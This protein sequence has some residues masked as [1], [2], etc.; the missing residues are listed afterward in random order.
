[1]KY[2]RYILSVTLVLGLTPSILNAQSVLIDWDHTWNYLHPI[3]GALPRTSGTSPHPTGTTPWHAIQ[4]EFEASYAGPSFSASA[5]GFEGGQGTAPF[6]YGTIDYFGNPIPAPG[7]FSSFATALPI[8]PTGSRYTNYFRTT[9][10]VPDDGA[11]YNN[12][13]LRYILDD[14]GFIYLN[15]QLILQVNMAAGI[16]DAYSTLAA[17]TVATETELRKAEL[18]LA[19]GSLTGGNS[20]TGLAGN[21]TVSQQVLELPPG[22]HT[23]A[24]AVHSASNGSSDM[25]LALQLQAGDPKCTMEAT[26]SN[27]VES[28]GGTPGNPGDDT[29]SFVLNVSATG[30]FGTSWK[31][32]APTSAAHNAGGT[33]GED[34]EISGL[35]AGE[36]TDGSLSLAIEDADD[37]LCSTVVTIAAPLVIASD[38][39]G[40]SDIPVYT[41]PDTDSSGWIINGLERSMTMNN[42]GGSV[43]RITS[44]V[45]RL[46][47]SREILFSGVLKIDDTSSGT[48]AADSFNAYLIL[49]GNPDNTIS[50]ITPYDTGIADGIL[51]G[52][53]LAPSPG[54]YTLD[55]AATI[56]SSARS[57]QIVIEAINNSDSEIFT[58]SDLTFFFPAGSEPKAPLG[59]ERVG[60]QLVFT[61]ASGSGLL[62]NLRSESTNI[63]SD[64]LTWPIF[65]DQGALTATPPQ[66]TLTVPMP[67]EQSRLFVIESY[68][69]PPE[70][71]YGSDFENGAEEWETGSEGADGTVWELG[72]P[73][74]GPSEAFSPDNCFAT[75]LDS[76][77]ALNANVYLRSPPIVLSGAGGATL[78]FMHYYD[79]E[80]PEPVAPFTV[81][82]FGKVS[83]LDAADDSEIAVLIP[84]LNDF[85][86]DWELS[87]H[88]IPAEALDRTIKIEFRLTTDDVAVFAGWYI[89]DFEVTIP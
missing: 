52:A 68:P 61:W 2:R 17:G 63:S 36:F 60:D 51:S 34:V 59:V 18:N 53:E 70:T 30:E 4:S 47:T 81:Y 19:A 50:L 88:A 20:S 24:V 43:R 77:Y 67:E 21:A 54:S 9:F 62:Y 26:V 57:A 55:F 28:D 6:G 64:P 22:E 42:P 15:G 84:T 72:I 40:G 69:A 3:A 79:I 73:T 35:P 29:V 5:P 83:I 45:V 86:N 49:D 71:V 38:R 66:N 76:E 31:I 87:T 78:K 12:P 14:G 7:E 27:I 41:A 8:P 23:L 56:P 11:T 33:Y 1:M 37:A 44:E 82:D 39:R 13:V 85:I 74:S 80:P 58:V 10:T 46:A 65:G 25:L 89:D 32:N 75:N 16:R 48:E